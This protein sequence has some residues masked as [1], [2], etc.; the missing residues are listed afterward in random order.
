MTEIQSQILST[1]RKGAI[2][3]LL[4]PILFV[5]L[6]VQA[7]TVLGLDESPASVQTVSGSD[8]TQSTRFLDDA[9]ETAVFGLGVTDTYTIYMPLVFKPLQIPT[10]LSV[11]VPTSNNN[12]ATYDMLATWQDVGDP[13]VVYVLEEATDANFTNPTVY[14][15]GTDTSYTITHTP[16]TTSTFYYR[17]RI[18]RGDLYS[19]WSNVIQQSGVYRDAFTDPSSGWAIRRQDLDDT[20]NSLSYV[21]GRLRLKI[22]GRWDS[23]Y[24]SPMVVS[25][26][27]PG[28]RIHTRVAL[29][30]G[31]DNLHS[32][33]IVFGGNWNP[34]EPCP[35]STYSS[36]FTRFYRLNAIWHGA[37]S[38]LFVQL[39]RVDGYDPVTEKD[40]G[41]NLMPFTD[42]VVAAPN[43]WNDWMIDV[44]KDGTI[45]LYAGTQLI[46]E[47]KDTNFVGGGRYFGGFASADEYLGTAAL[48]EFYQILP[49]P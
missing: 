32:Y 45:R 18:E 19:D 8:V 25:P 42:V 16:S 10:L 6:I 49:A 30:E 13:T 33:G 23:M 41:V 48:Y 31:I 26:D 9:G 7:I 11:G 2:L 24:A 29:S 4:L 5:F 17:L 27:W 44:Y 35:N 37:P 3:A 38:S 15:A 40:I 1:G 47:V 34:A 20:A 12:F 21:N 14:N 43:G 36:C 46:Y 22:G 39:R 28:Y